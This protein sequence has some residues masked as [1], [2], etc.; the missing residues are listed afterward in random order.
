MPHEQQQSAT[1]S[2]EPDG[3]SLGV[4][5]SLTRFARGDH[6]QFGAKF[7]TRQIW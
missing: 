2:D 3:S 7:K 4:A 6:Q 5:E 1:P